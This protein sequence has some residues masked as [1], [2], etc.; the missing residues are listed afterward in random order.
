MPKGKWLRIGGVGL[1][2]ADV[3]VDHQLIEH[4]ALALFGQRQVLERVIGRRRLW[5]AGEH[6]RLGPVETI[7]R[8]AE[9]RGRNVEELPA[10]PRAQGASAASTDRYLNTSLVFRARD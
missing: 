1:G 2:L 7:G 5:Q 3:V 10:R 9:V 8:S 4:V 6:R